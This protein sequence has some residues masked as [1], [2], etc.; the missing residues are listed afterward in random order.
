MTGIQKS[1]PGFMRADADHCHK[2]ANLQWLIPVPSL[3]ITNIWLVTPVLTY[4]TQAIS[5]EKAPIS[6]RQLLIIIPLKS[7]PALL[8]PCGKI[9]IYSN[10][11]RI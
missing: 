4:L 5:L 10:N 1:T 6:L 7:Q 2:E 9:S 8:R 11:P 3:Q